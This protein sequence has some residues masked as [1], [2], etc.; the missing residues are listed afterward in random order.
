M[1]F[2]LLIAQLYFSC[3]SILSFSW[4]YNHYLLLV[5][6]FCSRLMDIHNSSSHTPEHPPS[7]LFDSLSFPFS[8]TYLFFFSVSTYSFACPLPFSLL[9]SCYTT[10][11]YSLVF[12]PLTVT[13]PLFDAYPYTVALAGMTTFGRISPYPQCLITFHLY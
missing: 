13:L 5:N 4:L 3:P 1:L 11:Y 6:S 7:R 2:H 9:L 10:L 8:L 12:I